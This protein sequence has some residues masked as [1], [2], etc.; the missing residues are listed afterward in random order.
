MSNEAIATFTRVIELQE[1]VLHKNELLES[2]PTFKML[3]E[4]LIRVGKITTGIKYAKR[5]LEI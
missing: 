1:K 2:I 5:A 4:E 3:S